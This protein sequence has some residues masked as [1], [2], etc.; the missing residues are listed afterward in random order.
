MPQRRRNPKE[1]ESGHDLEEHKLNVDYCYTQS[2]KL[3]AVCFIAIPVV[4]TFMFL[5]G[6]L[7]ASR[8]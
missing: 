1:I 2:E 6:L 7:L 5:L 4:S 8:Q 3:L